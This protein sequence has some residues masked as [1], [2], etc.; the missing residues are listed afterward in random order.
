MQE[1][2]EETAD[3]GSATQTARVAVVI[4]CFNDGAF[5][6]DALHSIQEREAVE[7]VV[8]DDGSTDPATIETLSRFTA[9]GVDVRHQPNR[10]LSAARMAGVAATSAPYVF[11]LDADDQLEPGS[12]ATLAD[13]LDSDDSV[14]FVY[15]HLE[16]TGTRVGGRRAQ[17]WNPFTLLY[18]NRWGANCL[19]RRDAL[20]AVGGWS[21]PDIYEDWDIL[22][23]LAEHGYRGAPVDQLVLHYRRHASARL[24][25][26]GHERYATLYRQLRARHERLFARRSE[27]AAQYHVARWRRLVYPLFFGTRRLYPFTVHGPVD[28]LRYQYERRARQ[29]PSRA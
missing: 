22:L 27:L 5:V 18:A 6:G 8:V 24:T 7:V 2:P 9:R 16:F 15:G 20:L 25:T 21:F 29:F 13:A 4:P 1:V 14:S 12:L 11:P 19:Y 3:A 17:V 26:S 10:G 23:A 28:N